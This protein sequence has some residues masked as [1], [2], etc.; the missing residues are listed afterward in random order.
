MR[1]FFP[2]NALRAFEASARH[3]NFTRAGLELNVTQAAVSQQV[4]LLEAQ[5]G[6]ALFKRLPRGL[7]MTEQAQVLLP[8]LTESFDHIQTVLK[9]FEGGEFHEVLT[10]ATVGTFAVGWLL[11]RL[12]KFREKYPFIELKLLTNNNVVNLAAEGLDFA[13]R[14]GEGSWSTS[15]N[16]LLFDA[17]LTVLCSPETAKRLAEPGDLEKETLLRSYR[18]EEWERWLIQA[19]LSPWRPNGMIFDSSRLMVE[20]AIQ[21]VGAALAPAKMF[22]RELTTGVLIRPFK[23]E[24]DMGSYWLTRLKSKRLT[25]AMQLFQDWICQED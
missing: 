9:R 19:G 7:E 13:I 23:T 18:E 25:S 5:L 1:S 17:P 15:D 24:I 20:A 16:T 21:N 4:R 10:I 12:W 8:V 6:T 14:F 2:L 11:P 22:E 3:L